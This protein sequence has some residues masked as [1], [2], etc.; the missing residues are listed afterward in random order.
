M[1]TIAPAAALVLACA[2]PALAGGGPAET[3]V[4]VN[5]ASADSKKVAE[6]YAARRHIPRSQ[7][8]EV[9]C[10]EG[11][12][13]PMDDF[14]RDV[15]DPLRAFLHARGL[16]ERCRFVVMTQGMPIL[17]KTP[18][19]PVSTAAALGLL[20]TSVC[21]QP[22]QRQP[23]LRNTYTSGPAPRET[24]EGGGRRLL[25]TA[26]ISTTA[27]EAMALVDRSVASDGTA[28]KDALFI[29]QDANGPVAAR[30]A[31]LDDSRQWL[32]DNGW[33]GEHVGAGADKVRDRKKIMG[34]LS[35]GH[36][37]DL[38]LE[39]VK[40]NE[41]L[42][43][44]ICDMLE[45]QGAF[46]ANFGSDPSKFTQ[47]PVTHMIRAGVT[48]VHGAVAD[49][50]N[51]TFPSH[52]LFRAYLEGYTLAETY[53]QKLPFAYW[54]NL[55]I[56]D[57][58][59]A[60]Y[61]KRPAVKAA[62]NTGADGKGTVEVE[63]PGAVRIEL[64]VDG[65]PAGS[66]TGEKGSVALD[67]SAWPPGPHVLLVE[68]T[69]AGLAEPRGWSVAEF[70]GTR[71]S[72]PPAPARAACEKLLVEAPGSITAGEAGT[73]KVRAVDASGKPVAGW[74]ERIEVRT[75]SPPVRWS[76]CDAESAEADVA[77]TLTKAGEYELRVTS[78][79]DG[80]EATA[81][82]RVVPGEFAHITTP[83]EAF[84]ICQ[85]ADMEV[86]AE[87]RFGNAL[88]AWEGTVSLVVQG[89]RFAKMPPAVTIR[90]GDGGRGVLRGTLLTN[91]GETGLIFNDADGGLISEPG[92]RV[93]VGSAPL[94]PWLVG[95]PL[96]AK[97]A[98]GDP[99]QALSGPGSVL[100]GA[101][102]S[103]RAQGGVVAF[104]AGGEAAVAVTWIEALGATKARLLAAAPGRLR[105][106]LDG[107]PVFDGVPQ[108]TDTAAKR[109]KIADL[110]LAEGRHRL[111]VVADTKGAA[112]MALEIDDGDGKFPTSLR[113]R[114]RSGEAPKSFVAS[115][116]V[117]GK[118][119][120]GIAGA[121]VT[122]KDAAGKE[123]TATTVAD[124]TWWVEGV[125]AGDLTVKVE[126][127]G[128]TFEEAERTVTIEEEHAADVDF[129]EAK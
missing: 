72:P 17:A 101:L 85:E 15:V 79:A 45:G 96:S 57:P 94:W 23:W 114:A 107:K 60:P 43:G 42:P 119:G 13:I 108:A 88:P 35:G 33:T 113:V 11:L 104:P 65:A 105:I 7:I 3:V 111:T 71:T 89:D 8:C 66:V 115:G 39:G 69:G 62:V 27:D 14:V 31:H 29:Y 63:A 80:R 49:P 118:D 76:A 9:K 51:F 56:G 47:F 53:H 38:T 99:A 50:F 126:A 19:G 102:V 75:S 121:A 55:T 12:E 106:L 1:R 22:Q 81:R 25:V 59:C 52:T 4:L 68:A 112:S 67:A 127:G 40:T 61:A 77:V 70:A 36:W 20:D 30:N 46:P 32:A 122:L 116:R 10:A 44:A 82:V 128:R 24:L 21:G 87:D 129:F 92:E 86:V 41:F 48:G 16:D 26:L 91:S 110:E 98:E 73:L 123:S 125:A 74:K 120:A 34:W 6:H 37:S 64:Y 93:A 54:M 84:P 97:Q 109:E 2:L 83:L 95:G 58:L 90:A 103:R 124:G 117:R 100:S 28:P 18:G 5:S 78:P